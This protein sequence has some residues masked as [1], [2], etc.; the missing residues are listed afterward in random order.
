MADDNDWP[1]VVRNLQK[2]RRKWVRLTRILSREGADARTSGQIYLAVVQL[3]QL[4]GSETWVMT[5][6]IGRVLGVFHHRLAHRL[7]GRQPWRG[8]DG[9]WIYPPL[10][11]AMAEAGLQEVDTYVSRCQNTVA[12]FIA[13]R[14]IRNLCLAAE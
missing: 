11:D 1:A 8:R 3:V 7:T 13:T 5:P 10:E 2:S 6:Y 9:V 12:Q 4:Y 14:P